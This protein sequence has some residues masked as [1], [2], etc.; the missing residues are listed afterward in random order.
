[1][2]TGHRETGDG[3][4]DAHP[5]SD[6]PVGGDAPTGAL[7]AGTVGDRCVNCGAPLSSDQRYCVICGERRG[8][9]RFSLPETATAA[10]DSTAPVG[11]PRPPRS[12]RFSSGATLV[13]GVGT[14]LLALG[15]G[16]LIGHGTADTKTPAAQIIRVNG[17]SGS[18]SG[19]ASGSGSTATTGTTANGGS[20]S[21]HPSGA[22]KTGSKP[23]KAAAKNES[24]AAQKVLGGKAKVPPPTVTVGSKGS[25]A[26]YSKK[27]HK[28]TGSFFGQ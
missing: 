12:P 27:T 6:T 5:S 23:T 1:M 24:S 2:A 8:S 15:V 22:K 9:P 11:A 16:V 18:S 7:V 4:T 21:K 26:G 28:F 3:Q 13:A 10:D 17:G 19:S 20:G 25:G 14:L